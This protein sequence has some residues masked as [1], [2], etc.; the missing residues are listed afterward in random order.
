MAQCEACGFS[1][2]DLNRFCGQC[3]HTLDRVPVAVNAGAAKLSATQTLQPV[4]VSGPSILGLDA[5]SQADDDISYLL[6]DE[7]RSHRAGFVILFFVIVLLL[8]AAAFVAYQKFYFL[9]PYTGKAP[10]M[11]APTFAYEHTPAS[12]LEQFKLTLPAADPVMPNRSLTDQLALNHISET[13]RETNA[14]EKAS[15]VATDKGS[16][17]LAEGEKYLY[18]RGVASNCKLAQ[19]NFENAADAGNA[20]AMSHLGSMYG[21]GRCVKFDRV[22]AYGWFAKAKNADPNNTWLE[23]SMDMLWRN[24][25]AK[26]RAAILK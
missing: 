26:E 15:A 1:N 18:G 10:V 17:L 21:S 13:M 16:Q 9:A 25:N 8:A 22:A 5:I 2:S 12:V 6:E 4:S 23:S 3:G 11:I 24:M 19:E 20:A 14:R 7:P